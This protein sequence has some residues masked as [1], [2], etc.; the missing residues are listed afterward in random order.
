MAQRDTGEVDVLPAETVC[1]G[2]EPDRAIVLRPGIKSAELFEFA[3]FD[4]QAVCRIGQ[5][6]ACQYAGNEWPWRVRRLASGVQPYGLCWPGSL[7][8]LRLICCASGRNGLIYPCS[9]SARYDRS[10]PTG[11]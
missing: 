1:F 7:S 8:D 11:C 10:S 9:H 2:A 3:T 5:H 4:H 6:V